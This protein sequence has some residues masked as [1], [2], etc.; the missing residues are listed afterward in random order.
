MG[1]DITKECSFRINESDD[2]YALYLYHKEECI[3]FL[4]CRR[5]IDGMK[6]ILFLYDNYEEDYI[7]EEDIESEGNFKITLNTKNIIIDELIS[8]MKQK[9]IS[10]DDIK[11]ELKCEI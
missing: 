11:K 1:Q 8:V 2:S 6:F 9:N 7:I 5:T 10:I 4:D 3:G